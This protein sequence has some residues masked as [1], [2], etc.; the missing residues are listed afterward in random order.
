MANPLAQAKADIEAAGPLRVADELNAS[1][2]QYPYMTLGFGG[3]TPDDSEGGGGREV[4][5]TIRLIVRLHCGPADELRSLVRLG[6]VIGEFLLQLVAVTGFNAKPKVGEAEDLEGLLTVNA[7]L[8]YQQ[9]YGQEQ[10]GYQVLV[11]STADPED[12]FEDGI[13]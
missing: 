9:D 12:E 10:D 13:E 1:G 8:S 4:S 5:G 6:D 7:D 2:R 11:A 3:F